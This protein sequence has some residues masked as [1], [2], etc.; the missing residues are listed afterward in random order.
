MVQI[1]WPFKESMH[2]S[3][4]GESSM[5]RRLK[6]ICYGLIPITLVGLVTW[7]M[8]S[9][10]L[11]KSEPML[12][13]P[14]LEPTSP[15]PQTAGPQEIPKF[16]WPPPRASATAEIPRRFFSSE[17]GE[18]LR[19]RDVKRA[20]QAALESCGY[21][22]KSY[23]S[24]PSGFAMVTRL[25]QINHDGTS[26][27]PPDRWAVE[28]QRLRKFSLKAYLKALFSAN[29]GYYRIIVFAVTTPFY[30]TEEI[31]SRK[32]A[33]EWLWSGLNE[34]PDSIGQLE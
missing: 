20:L 16:P 10:A 4:K 31:V 5:Q 13:S 32:E 7:Y 21:F 26:K 22:E 19:L 6:L 24:V 23:Y 17:S 18:L 28:V 8:W 27:K 11:T 12:P 33:M 9:I 2:K 15:P 30:Q 34:L 29:P 25:E 3:R 1:A 14:S